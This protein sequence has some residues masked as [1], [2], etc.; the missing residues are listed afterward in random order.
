MMIKR[1]GH[2]AMGKMLAEG[3]IIMPDRTI[4]RRELRATE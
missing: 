2:P 1:P 4:L 3:L